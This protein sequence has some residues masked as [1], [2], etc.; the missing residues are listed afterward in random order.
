VGPLAVVPAENIVEGE[1]ESPGERRLVCGLQR[2]T[3]KY[4]QRHLDTQDP[5]TKQVRERMH[6]ALQTALL[7][8]NVDEIMK[9]KQRSTAQTQTNDG[10]NNIVSGMNHG[11]TICK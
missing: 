4:L 11:V 9:R 8:I 3:D 2:R 7:G 1:R 5:R 10:G 6:I